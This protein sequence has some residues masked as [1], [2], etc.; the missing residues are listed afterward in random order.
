L[1]DHRPA[2]SANNPNP[3]LNTG[4]STVDDLARIFNTALVATR[5]ESARDFSAELYALIE[6]PAFRSI[7]S[8]IKQ[9]ARAQGISEREAAEAVIQTFRKVDRIWGEYVFQEGID[10]LRGQVGPIPS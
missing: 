9:M 8:A 6:S 3:N 4:G 5:A 1:Y 7:L 2:A 10:R